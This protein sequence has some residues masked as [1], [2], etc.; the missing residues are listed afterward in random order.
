MTL[1]YTFTCCI[2]L[3]CELIYFRHSWHI[4]VQFVL[5][6]AALTAL[7]DGFGWSLGLL[8]KLSMRQAAF[9]AESE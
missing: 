9:T 7:S 1:P 5:R 8:C 3:A 2:F 4:L 6:N